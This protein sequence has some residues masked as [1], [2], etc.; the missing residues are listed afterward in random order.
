MFKKIFKPLLAA[1]TALSILT[2]G[3]AAALA[4]E[5][6]AQKKAPQR[7]TPRRQSRPAAC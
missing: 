7:I 6:G 1:A 2:C 5:T 3:N 4:V